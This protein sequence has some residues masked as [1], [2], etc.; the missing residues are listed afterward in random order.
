MPGQQHRNLCLAELVLSVQRAHQPGFFELREARVG[1]ATQQP[2]LGAGC[3]E[4]VL[5]VQS[6]GDE[7]SAPKATRKAFEN[8]GSR[9]K[10]LLWLTRSNHVLLWDWDN[11]TVKERIEEFLLGAKP[12]L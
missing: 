12:A 7:A 1:V 10:E 9:R 5:V 3:V 11:E 4:R 6:D 2:Y 8:L